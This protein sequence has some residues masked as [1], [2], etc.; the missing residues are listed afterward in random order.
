[1]RGELIREEARYKWFMRNVAK[2]IDALNKAGAEYALH[3]FRKPFDHVSVDLDILISV[4]GMSKAVK[5]LVRR[6]FKVAVP[7]PYTATLIR[8]GFIVDL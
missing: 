3:K 5:V 1:M 8:N 6:G 7:E 2:V 4:D